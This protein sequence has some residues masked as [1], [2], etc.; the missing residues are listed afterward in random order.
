M[1]AG[2]LSGMKAGGGPM[3]AKP[4]VT[5]TGVAPWAFEKKGQAAGPLGAAS[6]PRPGVAAERGSLGNVPEEETAEPKSGIERVREYMRRLC[7]E[8]TAAPA[9]QEYAWELALM[10]ETP[11][12]LPTLKFH[13]LVFGAQDLGSGAFSTVKYARTIEKGK[14]RAEWPEYA[15]KVIDTK[16]ME[17]LGYEACVNR[18]I[19][20]LRMLSHPGIAR[21]VSSFRWRDGA[22]LVLEY[23]SKG[24][25]HSI[26]R[27]QGS[28][29]EETAKFVLGEILA[30]L[31]AIHEIGFVYGDL[32]PENVV[33]TSA[34]HAK[35]TDFG[36]CR[37][38][39]QE[40]LERTNQSLLSQLRDGDWRASAT[41]LAP[42][43]PALNAAVAAEK[44]S[45][46][47][48][49]LADE[50][51]EGTTMYLPPEVVRGGPPTLAADAWAFACLMYQTITGRP[52][53]WVDDAQL[54]DDECEQQLRSRIVSFDPSS[55]L[56]AELLSANAKSLINSLLEADVEKRM[57]IEDAAATPFFEGMDVF[58]LYKKPRGPHLEKGQAAPVV[59]A[60]WQ[61][62]QYSKIWTVMPNP[63]DYALPEARSRHL[64]GA[65]GGSLPAVIA[66]TDLECD[67]PF[68]EEVFGLNSKPD[69]TVSL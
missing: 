4:P 15:V 9:T 14:P 27:T 55:D 49:D 50:R 47:R 30:A 41:P 65:G 67:S 12:L 5:V 20:V 60:R 8:G 24:D 10:A 36:G 29:S 63:Q 18:E 66:E 52:P 38:L 2:P 69:T 59:D 19:C 37:P 21:M 62:R 68:V 11:T 43:D 58:S 3:G 40:A 33:I 17:E 53:I 57:R 28:L 1:K 54:A 42:A 51:V 35:L 31:C 25:L 61:K 45:G 64:G 23:A 13:Q 7:P 6:L 26:I 44:S 22:Y 56:A 48:K 16:T 32:K 46:D 39:T 34:G